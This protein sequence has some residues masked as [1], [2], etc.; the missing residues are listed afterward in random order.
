MFL[1]VYLLCV[2]LHCLLN[3]LSVTTLLLLLSSVH[4]KLVAIISGSDKYSVSISLQLLALIFL[5]VSLYLP[6]ISLILNSPK[7]KKNVDFQENRKE[8]TGLFFA[9]NFLR[10]MAKIQ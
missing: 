2:C 8:T 4:F 6:V 9:L 7:E 5:I 3:A 1:W 10:I